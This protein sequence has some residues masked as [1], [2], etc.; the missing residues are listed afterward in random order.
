MKNNDITEKLSEVFPKYENL[1]KNLVQALKL[2]LDKNNIKYVS[3]YYRVKELASFLEKIE[4]KEYENP[5][6]EIEDICGVRIICY[7]QSDIQKISKIIFKEFEIIESDDKEGKLKSDQF[8][9]RSLHFIASIKE[10]WSKV[11]NYSDLVGLKA[12]IQV[13]TI[14]MHAWAEIEHNLAYKSEAHIPQKFKRKLSRISAKLEEADEQFEEL[15]NESTNLQ[16]EI[17]K[18]AKEKTLIFD[19]ETPIN[20]DTLQAFLNFY[21]PDRDQQPEHA[22]I[23]IDD[24]IKYNIK[25][26]DIVD[27]IERLKSFFDEIEQ[28]LLTNNRKFSQIGIARIIMY[29]IEENYTKRHSETFQRIYSE[30]RKKYFVAK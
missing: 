5:L 19:N 17:L 11:P 29:I 27:G 22:S 9:Y 28:K 16:E 2:L 23:L 21:F 15:K 13:R 18:K 25:F 4:R 7:Y 12:E 3:V 24:M 26:G 30:L 20:L 6:S 10:A 14:L 1:G 8:G